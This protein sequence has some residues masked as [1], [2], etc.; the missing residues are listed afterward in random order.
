M[1]DKKVYCADCKHSTRV[2]VNGWHLGCKKFKKFEHFP[3]DK[4]ILYGD[5]EKYNKNNK[6]DAYEPSL[7]KKIKDFFRKE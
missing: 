5:P 4:M 3:E 2:G 6:C 1:S 7:F